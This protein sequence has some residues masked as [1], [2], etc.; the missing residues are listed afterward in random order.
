[1]AENENSYKSILKGT[2]IL[3]SVQVFQI[4]VNLIRGKFVA[5]FLG[6]EGMGIASLF[7]S[8]ANTISR[9]ASMGLN[10]SFVKEVASRRDD[11]DR[12]AQTI[13][14]AKLLAILTAILGALAT[15]LLATPLSI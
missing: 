1:M 6:P 3:G 15:L 12:L 10:L 8:S 2:S 14:I 9:F 7:N 13:L 11:P 4:L 5:M